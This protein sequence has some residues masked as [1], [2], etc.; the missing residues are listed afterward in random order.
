MR[1]LT[2]FDYKVRI[3]DAQLTQIIS[4]DSSVKL[5][6]ELLSM[7]IF[8]SKLIQ[9]YDVDAE[10]TDTTAYSNTATY[11]ANAL[12]YL[13]GVTWSNATS[14]T[15]NQLVVYTD[16][17]VYLRNATTGGYSAGTLPTNATYFTLLGAK[18]DYFSTI[19][20]ESFW[21][22][23]TSYVVGDKVFYKNKVY[24]ATNNN[25]AIAPDDIN[26]GLSN[27]GSGVTYSV[28]AGQILNTSKFE[29]KD[30]RNPQVVNYMIDVIVYELMTRIPQ[31]QIPQFRAEKYDFVVNK[32]LEDCAKGDT[33][34]L[35]IPRKPF[36]QGA[37]IRV[38]QNTKNVNSY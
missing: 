30:N 3:Q 22:Y 32:W 13:D 12:V 14:Y 17:N 1:Y 35:N 37:R 7:D 4:G 31:R 15:N 25:I 21:D 10:F 20:P 2:D 29:K 23:D 27:W 6:C 38:S 19:V 33:L 24:T 16:S 9:K 34:T 18:H 28:S 36:R 11:N 26:F 5:D 8:R